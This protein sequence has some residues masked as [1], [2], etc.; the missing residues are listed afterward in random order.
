MKQIILF[1]FIILCISACSKGGDDRLAEQEKIRSKEQ[2]NAL[3]KNQK[4]W[5]N[6]MEKDLNQRK[7]FI[8]AIGGTFKGEVAV[9]DLYFA[10]KTELSPSIPIMFSDRVRTL[11]E[12]NYEFENLG[13]NI[14]VKIENPRVP[15]SAVSCT[16]EGYKPNIEKGLINI[17]SESCKN[18]FKFMLS[19]DVVK[20]NPMKVK[21]RARTLAKSIRR[22][23]ITS[24]DILNGIFESSASTKEY[25]FSLKRIN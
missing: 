4:E 6:K 3:N 5:A 1:T 7:Y 11:D 9:E 12:I 13:I 8:K 19:D 16:V 21:S 24:I 17:I 22:N 10:I 18:I 14:S 15:N 25:Q 2:I 20:K 23:E